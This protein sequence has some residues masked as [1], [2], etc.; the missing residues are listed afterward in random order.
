[1]ALVDGDSLRSCSRTSSIRIT[2]KTGWG[3]LIP[4]PSLQRPQSA[5]SRETFDDVEL[6]S[7]LDGLHIEGIEAWNSLDNMA[8]L[9]L[10]LNH[11][12]DAEEATL[13][14]P[15]M[16]ADNW[17]LRDG[18]E[19]PLHRDRGPFRKWMRTLHRRAEHRRRGLSADAGFPWELHDDSNVAQPFRRKH[20]RKSSS[21]SSFG[22]V[23]AVKSASLSLT[24]VS[25]TARSRRNTGLSRGYS[26]SSR[27]SMNGGRLSEDSC[28]PERSTVMDPV[29]ME[30]SLQRRRILEE[31]INTEEGYIGDIRALMNVSWPLCGIHTSPEIAYTEFQVYVTILASLPTLP[32]GLRSSINR[33]LTEIVELHEELLGDLHRTV[34]HSEYTQIDIPIPLSQSSSQG[35]R[36]MRSLDAVPEN[37]DGMSWLSNVRGM[38]A[39]PQDAAEVAKVFGKKASPRKPLWPHDCL[40]G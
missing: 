13:P 39:D 40:P 24:S 28:Y 26:R 12:G 27:T 15:Q 23:A 21:D 16:L 7:C 37:R 4:P 9:G 17:D 14:F 20:R 3:T 33:N 22:F 25:V 19:E 31:L 8:A 32:I 29:A 18:I 38:T 10:T 34:P 36:R 2:Q 1:M 35:H 6:S 11:P 30:R 5:N